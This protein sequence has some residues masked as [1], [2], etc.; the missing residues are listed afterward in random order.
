MNFCGPQQQ[1]E[2]GHSCQ[3]LILRLQEVSID[4]LVGRLAWT[5]TRWM[6]GWMNDLCWLFTS[7]IQ[8]VWRKGQNNPI[9]F[10]CQEYT[11]VP[12]QNTS[13]ML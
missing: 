2:L 1:R 6:H 3:T 9:Q 8:L 5:Q 10:S 12:V 7:T 13:V 11:A 4:I